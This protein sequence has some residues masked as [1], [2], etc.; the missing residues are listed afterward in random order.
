MDVKIIS[1]FFYISITEAIIILLLLNPSL[2][3]KSNLN[4]KGD[5]ILES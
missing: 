2:H 4:A 5:E 3:V 1:T